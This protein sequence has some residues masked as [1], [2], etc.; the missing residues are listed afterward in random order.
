MS[1]SSGEVITVND[2]LQVYEPE[3]VRWIFASYKTNV[4]FSISFDLDVIKT[5]EDFDRQERLAY[6]V[7]KGNA[8][9]VAMATRVF[10]LSQ[11]SFVEASSLQPENLPFQPSFRHLTNILQINHLDI[12]ATREYYRDQI[13][14][15]RDERRF[16]RT[17]PLC[18]LLAQALRPH[19]F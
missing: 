14:T 18:H 19:R 15:E 5:Y 17:H 6:Q 4:D 1:S 7:E 8:K 10:E 16:P 13:K 9:K 12:E 2:V 11:L 3:M